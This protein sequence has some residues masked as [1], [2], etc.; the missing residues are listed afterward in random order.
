MKN[1]TL[2]PAGLEDI[3]IITAIYNSNPEF[4]LDHLGVSR[5]TENF[6]CDEMLEM[7]RQGFTTRLFT[8][9]TGQAVGLADY[10]PD[11]TAY[12]S[13]L[14]LNASIQGQGWGRRCYE[15]LEQQ[16][17]AQGCAQVRLDAAQG[18]HSPAPFWE[19]L[20]FIPGETICLTW[21]GHSFPATVMHKDITPPQKSD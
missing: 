5:V 13:L 9:E 21:G 17:L 1:L 4:L 7:Q 20:G 3:G 18:P 14:M 6:L 8:T 12:L 11:Q 15:L 10:R 19:K 16:L 2:R